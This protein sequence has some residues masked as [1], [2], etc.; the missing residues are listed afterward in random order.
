VRA[1]V[2]APE[3][4]SETKLNSE[5]FAGI[6]A[7]RPDEPATGFD[8]GTVVRV[9]AGGVDL[10]LLAIVI[11]LRGHE[12]DVVPVSVEVAY[13]ALY[14]LLLEDSLLGYA[15]MAQAWNA[16]TV[17]V[18]QIV[19]S[20]AVV[21]LG[22]LEA[23]DEVFDAARLGVDPP[24]ELNTGSLVVSDRDIR[25][26]FQLRSREFAELFYERKEPGG[27]P[28]FP[29]FLVASV[30]AVDATIGELDKRVREL[31]PKGLDEPVCQALAGSAIWCE[32]V[33]PDVFGGQLV[34]FANMDPTEELERMLLAC[35]GAA[36]NPYGR[37]AAKMVNGA[38]TGGRR[39]FLSRHRSAPAPGRTHEAWVGVV[40]E[41]MRRQKAAQSAAPPDNSP[42]GESS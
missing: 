10:A 28:D 36:S 31:S 22:T 13:A 8:T 4:I 34:Q 24:A 20:L 26:G 6:A 41:A 18:D 33:D 39:S 1:S 42:D 15:A 25:R 32:A 2:A 19:D 27:E 38:D 30:E 12:V 29:T 17:L 3:T 40:M 5:P 23:V 14:D 16:G 11:D 9:R 37:Q 21:D 7:P 35:G